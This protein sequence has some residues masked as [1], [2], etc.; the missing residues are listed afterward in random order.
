MS[1]G[2]PDWRVTVESDQNYVLLETRTPDRKISL[3]LY[4]YPPDLREVIKALTDAQEHHS[5]FMLNRKNKKMFEPIESGGGEST[6]IEVPRQHLNSKRNWLGLHQRPNIPGFIYPSFRTKSRHY[7]DDIQRWAIG[8]GYHMSVRLDATPVASHLEIDA[9]ERAAHNGCVEP[10]A[11]KF[12]WFATVSVM[13]N[14][15]EPERWSMATWNLE[16]SDGGKTLTDCIALAW[17]EKHLWP[18][19]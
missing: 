3:G 17:S 7:S 1:Y 16:G 4:L 10:W 15:K 19:N 6:N 9:H 12:K 5:T 8:K 13:R 11:G 2:N 14:P 18:K